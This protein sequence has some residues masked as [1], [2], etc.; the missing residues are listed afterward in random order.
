MKREEAQPRCGRLSCQTIEMLVMVG[1]EIILCN[2]GRARE[3][4]HDGSGRKAGMA[5]A[6]TEDQ[7]VEEGC[8]VVNTRTMYVVVVID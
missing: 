8:C 5:Y 3:V 4:F 1:Q 6:V 7:A 2:H